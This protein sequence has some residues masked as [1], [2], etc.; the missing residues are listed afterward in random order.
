M[1]TAASM[2]ATELAG[3]PKGI[4]FSLSCQLITTSAAHPQEGRR[5]QAWGS[6][7]DSWGLLDNTVLYP[8]SH[9]HIRCTEMNDMLWVAILLQFPQRPNPCGFLLIFLPNISAPPGHLQNHNGTFTELLFPI[10]STFH[11][12]PPPT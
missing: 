1:N 7:G 3:E 11:S 10:F 2:N 9:S 8:F 6:S 12:I 5:P 4:G